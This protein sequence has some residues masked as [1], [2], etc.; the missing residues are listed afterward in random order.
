MKKIHLIILFLSISFFVWGQTTSSIFD[1][2]IDDFQN[3][4]YSQ[5]LS[6]F[7]QLLLDPQYADYHGDAYFWISRTL[8]AENRISDAER[9]LEFFLSNYQDNRYYAEG[10][11]QRGRILYLHARYEQAIVAF[12]DFI[13]QYPSNPFVANAYYWTGESLFDLG[14]L[15]Q[16]EKMF[17]AVLNEF[18]TSYRVEAARYRLAVISLS[19]REQELL[20]LL[21]W[22]Q[23]ESIQYIEEFH[24][25]ELEYQEAIAS[26]QTRMAN[27][28][29]ATVRVEL[30]RLTDS[31]S[32]LE[33]QR[34]TLQRQVVE[35][36][37]TIRRLE[38]EVRTLQNDATPVG[39]QKAAGT[40][41]IRS[42]DADF[43]QRLN[44]ISLKEETLALKASLIER[45]E[46]LVTDIEG[47]E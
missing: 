25:K 2:A 3:G 34:S 22:T 21:Q 41:T 46:G 23:E 18:P 47:G 19:R 10:L 30:N 20:K 36:R 28:S 5:A 44:L 11:Y 7:R 43:Q 27:F 9:N 35:Q 15:D 12:S 14:Q 42:T 40:V 33:G 37:G 16:S 38:N 4:R 24:K 1:S 17:S 6:S 26:Y 29:D 13:S 45:F 31:V 32:S 8:I 39:Q